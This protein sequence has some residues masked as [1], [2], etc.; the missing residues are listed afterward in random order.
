MRR[1]RPI[2]NRSHATGR[3]SPSRR[4]VSEGGFV[5]LN[6]F[7][8]GKQN[9]GAP[10]L[11]SCNGAVNEGEEMRATSPLRRGRPS[12][13]LGPAVIFLMLGSC[14]QIANMTGNS[15]LSVDPS[16]PCGSQRADFTRAKSYFT[17]EIVTD[18][19]AGAAAG[20]LGGAGLAWMTGK[21]VGSGA[22]IGGGVG[23]VAGGATGYTKVRAQQAR[24][25]A[26]MA[27]RVN[28]DLRQEGQEI[29]HTTAAFA[30]LRQCRYHQALLIKAQVHSNTLTR[31]AGLTQI[32]WER[33][34]FDEEIA[35]AHE[36]GVAMAKRGTQFRDAADALRSS[37]SPPPSARLVSTAASVSIPEKRNEFDKAVASAESSK[38]AAF[39]LDSNAKLSTVENADHPV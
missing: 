9:S 34:R 35:L 4:V 38:K 5:G 25:Q 30:R 22:L 12:R 27:Q 37:P 16:D 26:D 20:A 32:A 13:S 17:D 31:Q 2:T 39:D 29:D 36:Y 33:E 24:D 18:T 3:I 19:L 6:Y 14:S 23:A 15:R 7:T 10:C 8:L 11:L 21:N 28:S 1:Y